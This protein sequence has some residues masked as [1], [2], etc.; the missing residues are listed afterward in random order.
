MKSYVITFRPNGFYDQ[1]QNFE[2]V[3]RKVVREAEAYA[4]L[5][6]ENGMELSISKRIPVVAEKAEI[7]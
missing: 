1:D 6:T 5:L 2:C 7:D 3:R 4:D